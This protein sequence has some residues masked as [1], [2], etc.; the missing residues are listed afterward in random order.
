MSDIPEN[1]HYTEEHEYVKPIDDST[2]AV[3]ITDYAQGELG[4]VVYVDLPEVGSNFV[5]MD[6]F[7]TIE[8]N[9]TDDP[10]RERFAVPGPI[11]GMLEK[12]YLGAKARA[13]F[14]KKV[15][16]DDGK[17]KIQAIDLETLEYADQPSV[18]FDSIGASRSKETSG[19]KL[20]T[21][22]WFDDEAGK[23][24]PGAVA[25]A[26]PTDREAG[27]DRFPGFHYV[28]G[29]GLRTD[30]DGRCVLLAMLTGEDHTVRVTADG[31]ASAESAGHLP[32]TIDRPAE[33]TIRLKRE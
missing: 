13:G 27:R 17:S 4:D 11:A 20:A 1:L 28:P 7:G 2:V 5:P 26:G 10:W 33:V 32:G 12:G 25:L 18:K 3:G 22:V 30:S 24:I 29:W 23:P 6:V 9:C 31:Y 21:M 15:K 19:E 16:G 14:Y 8:E